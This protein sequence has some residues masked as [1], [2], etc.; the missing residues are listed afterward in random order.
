MGP[1]IQRVTE[2]GKVDFLHKRNPVFDE[3]WG[4]WSESHA[5]IHRAGSKF[6]RGGADSCAVS[7]GVD[8]LLG[9]LVPQL[10][11]GVACT[12]WCIDSALLALKTLPGP[13][14]LELVVDGDTASNQ[15]T[16]ITVCAQQGL[17]CRHVCQRV[18]AAAGWA[19]PQ[20]GLPGLLACWLG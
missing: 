12:K 19:L 1:S 9:S 10:Q 2:R 4:A 15:Q 14:S 16:M 11:D 6:A 7:T 5:W 18:P 3:R 8:V 13:C 17:Q 20:G